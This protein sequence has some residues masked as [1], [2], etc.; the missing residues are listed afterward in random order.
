[1]SM[2]LICA[3]IS[4]NSRSSALKSSNIP[5]EMKKRPSRMSRNGRM[6]LSTWWLYSVSASIIPAR[7][8]PRAIDKPAICEAQADASATSN[9]ARVNNSRRRL[10]AIT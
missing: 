10:L 6:T 8:A 7:N 3:M 4:Q 5:T 1:M 2:T 9:T